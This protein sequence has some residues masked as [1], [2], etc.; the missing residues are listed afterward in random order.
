[1]FTKKFLQFIYFQ[2]FKKDKN[3]RGFKTYEDQTRGIRLR[4]RLLLSYIGTLE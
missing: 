3:P 2:V 4:D 1:M